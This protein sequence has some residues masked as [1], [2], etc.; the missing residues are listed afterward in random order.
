MPFARRTESTMS[1]FV[2]AHVISRSSMISSSFVL[3]TLAPEHRGGTDPMEKVSKTIELNRSGFLF[4]ST[5]WSLF[6]T[7]RQIAVLRQGHQC[8]V[9]LLSHMQRS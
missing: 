4:C 5:F 3:Y 9:M 1:A 2:A 8:C 7:V 6:F